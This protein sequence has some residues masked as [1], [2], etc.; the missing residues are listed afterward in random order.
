MN[1]AQQDRL[2]AGAAK[3]GVT[4]DTTALQRFSAYLTLLQQWGKKINL[5]TRLD[6]DEIITYHFLD[7]LA[8]VPTLALTPTAK[9]VDIGTGAGLPGIA[10]KFA[11][12]DLRLL[13]LESV[14]KKVNFCQTVIRTVGISDAAALWGRGEE[15]GVAPLYHGAYDWAVSRALGAAADVARLA[16]PFL[17]EGGRVLLYKGAPEPEEL[18]A[19]DIFCQEHGASWSIQTTVVPH[20]RGARSL[21]LLALKP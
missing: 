11:L 13:L 15:V 4:L 2:L 9:V 12:P 3:M 20:L 18:R 14:R 7:S 16:R 17:T 8:G 10:L 19:L 5:T 1:R 21:I 6:A